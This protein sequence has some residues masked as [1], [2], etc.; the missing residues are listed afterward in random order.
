MV[1]CCSSTT[2]R[3]T[4]PIEMTP[5][6]PPLLHDRQMSDVFVGHQ[7]HALI[8]RPIRLDRDDPRRHDLAD[9]ASPWTS[10]Q[11]GSPSARS[12]S[13]RRCL[14]SS[15][16]TGRG[17]PR[18][19]CR[20]SVGER[21]K[22]DRPARRNTRRICHATYLVQW[23]AWR[24]PRD[25][26]GRRKTRDPSCCDSGRRDRPVPTPP[27]H[28]HETAAILLQPTWCYR[29][30]LGSAIVHLYCP[31]NLRPQAVGGGRCCRP[32]CIAVRIF[33]SP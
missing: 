2:A 27:R 16:S 5:D 1:N 19:S 7:R 10:C 24:V 12:P 15:H 14:R 9:Q 17:Q 23:P 13:P 11:E 29:T 28:A 20:P 32:Q 8:R 22:P 4:S 25:L 6:Q 33:G 26:P 3:T 21:R 30:K 31:W 18:C